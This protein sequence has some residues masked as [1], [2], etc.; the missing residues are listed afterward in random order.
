MICPRCSNELATRLLHNVE[1]DECSGCGGRWFDRDE[2]RLAKDGADPDLNWLD[3]HP[4]ND[5]EKLEISPNVAACPRC[6]KNMAT[7]IY[8]STKVEIDHCL[9]CRGVWLDKGEFEQIIEK[10]E[11]ELNGKDV[12][13]YLAVAL[14]EARDV[15]H[16]EEGVPSDLLDFLTVARMLRYRFLAEHPRLHSTLLAI[17]SGHP[18]R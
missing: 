10:L 18:F 12:S 17:Q 14:R 4:L 16:G 7:V 15:R 9:S 2:L 11:A 5:G 8:G 3:I 1:I 6:R 13:S